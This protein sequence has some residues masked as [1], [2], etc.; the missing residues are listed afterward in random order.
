MW[1]TIKAYIDIE[2][3]I[4]YTWEFVSVIISITVIA[5]F[6]F[7]RYMV[8]GTGYIHMMKEWKNENLVAVAVSFFTVLRWLW[9]RRWRWRRQL[10][11][12]LLF[13]CACWRL[14]AKIADII[15]IYLY[16]TAHAHKT[17]TQT[18]TNTNTLIPNL[19]NQHPNVMRDPPQRRPYL[20]YNKNIH[21]IYT[22][23]DSNELHFSFNE[24]QLFWLNIIVIIVYK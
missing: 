1:K 11:L 2:Q 24:L 23:D 7:F 21:K 8:Q 6:L 14:M 17:H 4:H 20:N 22:T 16:C 5:N 18:H 3:N 10:L 12:R 13:L 19:K 9:R 15:L